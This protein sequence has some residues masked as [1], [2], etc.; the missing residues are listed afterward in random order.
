MPT[1]GELARQDEYPPEWLAR[2]AVPMPLGYQPPVEAGGSYPRSAMGGL[3]A[4]PANPATPPEWWDQGVRK[5]ASAAA[6]IPRKAFEASETMRL[7]GVYDP[8]PV[9]EAASLAMTGGLPFAQ[10]GPQMS[11]AS[12]NAFLYNPPSKSP[13]AFHEDYK[14]GARA[15]ATGR[16]THDIESNLLNA[17]YVAGRRMVGGPD[18]PL[19]PA[20]VVAAATE[21]TGRG[22]QAVAARE[23]GG[24][25]GRF[26]V[27]RDRR[28]GNILGR[29][30]LY[31]PSLT[32]T[33]GGR[34]I[35]HE[36]GHAIDE[37]AGTIPTAGLNTELR[38]V[39]NTLNTGEE[40]TR[41]LMGPE[42][43]HYRGEDV[44][45]ELMAEAI[46]AYMADPN[47]LKSVA[48]ETATAIRRAVN[49]NPQLA[50]IIQ[51][52]MLVV[53]PMGGLA[54]QDSYNNR[55]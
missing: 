32:P 15:D 7:G 19:T 16:L 52:N 26:V 53:A 11:V 51:F 34:V 49:A 12:R 40:R 22:P 10:R 38:R 20:D 46:R 54:A 27:E 1:M 23:I 3:A 39:Y 47:Y 48:P 8:E 36:F 29:Q 33:A 37:L 44:P 35:A 24:D 55:Q 18:E 14:T 21:A 50:K 28:S 31:D 6:N 2:P 13:R 9:I 43:Q 5:A 30:I 4:P 45:R 17:R 25:A 42:R 41:K